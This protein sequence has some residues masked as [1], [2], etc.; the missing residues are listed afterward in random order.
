MNWV[1]E[2]GWSDWPA[3]A[4]LNLFLRILGRRADGYHC[5]QTVFQ[6]LD[7]GDTVRLRVRG[8]GRIVRHAGAVGVDPEADLSV[9]AARALAAAS[10]CKLGVDIAVE[11]RIPMGGG[12]GGGSSN[13]A[14]V[15]VALNHLWHCG[16]DIEAL[17][18]IG[19]TL[20]A[21][22]PV[23]VHGENAWAE[24]V[25]ELLTPIVLPAAAYLLVDPGVALATA[26]L[27]A[28]PELTR[29]AEPATMSAF[30]AG[31]VNDNAFAPVVTAR[32]PK[33]A[34]AMAALDVFGQARLTGTGG[35]CFVAF[36][37]MQGARRAWA[38]MPAGMRAWVAAGAA[39][40]P[41]VSTLAARAGG[42][43]SSQSIG[44][45]PSG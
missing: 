5:L 4:K 11:K 37:D 43:G 19:L 28:A 25:G 45:S 44:A 33:V 35:G 39:R 32:E 10:G 41:L 34:A 3:P 13:A 1:S 31:W 40:S 26:E 24:G 18:T 2:E 42:A 29:H 14:T 15:L 36:A 16:L 6:L 23:F 22:V 7:W 21:D 30:L 8:D 20:G 9:R 12:F 38:Q 27:F 17:A